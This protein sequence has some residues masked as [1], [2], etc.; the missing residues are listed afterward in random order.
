[1]VSEVQ[2]SISP[3][4][5]KV[6]ATV[7]ALTQGTTT[8]CPI[9]WLTLAGEPLIHGDTR[10]STCHH[11]RAFQKQPVN[12][13]VTTCLLSPKVLQTLMCALYDIEAGVGDSGRVGTTA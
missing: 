7:P 8:S 11:S 6:A 10:E 12:I 13:C 4:G 5:P 2:P 9:P 3:Q 1:M